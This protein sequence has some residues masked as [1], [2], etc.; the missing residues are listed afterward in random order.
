MQY[1]QILPLSSLEG[2]DSE[3]LLRSV[4]VNSVTG[5]LKLYLR[6]LPEA[7]FT[8]RLYARFLHVS[9]SDSF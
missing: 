9:S 1:N 6:Q 7:L 3:I 2:P 5:L 4:D 8:D